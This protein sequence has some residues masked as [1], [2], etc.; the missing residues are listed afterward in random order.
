MDI[1]FIAPSNSAN[2]YQ[3]LSTNLSA[4][5][6]PTWALILAQSCRSKGF[7]VHII[8]TLAENISDDDL[9]L[10]IKKLNP[11]IICFVAYGQNVNA[12]TT[13]MSGVVRQATE[14]KKSGFK[15]PISIVGSH[16]QVLP[17]ETLEREKSLDIVFLG[18]GVYPLHKILAIK[19]FTQENLKKIDGIA[20]RIKDKIVLNNGSPIVPKDRMDIDMPICLGSFAIQK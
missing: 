5:E 1:V 2:I 18:E 7:K 14:I 17:L 9:I 19:C 13:S 3:S 6:P 11:K 15:A 12:G 20:F 8:D 4:I 10:K 16:V